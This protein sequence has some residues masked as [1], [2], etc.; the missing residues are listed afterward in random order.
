MSRQYW[1]YGLIG[2][3]A[4]VVGVLLDRVL[5]GHGGP[6]EPRK[7]IPLQHPAEPIP[8][9]NTTAPESTKLPSP[10][11]S[12]AEIPANPKPAAKDLA[13]ILAEPDR[14]QRMTDL[15]AF[16]NS[17]APGAYGNALRGLRRISS[18][19]ERDL[20][21]RLL[22]ARWVQTDPE[23]AL[24]F[25]MA[26]RNYE[27]IANEVFQSEAAND[28]TTALGRA[29]A[30]T[31]PEL[32]YQ[33]LLGV[34]SFMADSN[35]SQAL[36]MAS[37]LGDI[38]GNEPLSNVIYRQWATNDPQ[39]AALAAAQA[40]GDGGWRSPI[41]QVARTW[42]SDDPQAA[43]NWSVGLTDREAQM[44]SISQVMRQWTRDDVSGATNWANSLPPGTSYDA[45]AAG[46][47]TSLA[48]NH[49]QDA[50]SWAQNISDP[51]MRTNVLQRVSREVMWRNP[52]NGAEI[53]GA[54][55]VPANLIPQPGNGGGRRRRGGGG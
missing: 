27:F 45:A 29:K 18:T 41:S 10:A 25:A 36:Q 14:R 50:V 52:T 8:M 13:T 39:G 17:L 47:A 11:L 3:I 26:N 12:E 22:V 20:A 44:R 31:S 24:N 46:L 35:P 34:L 21:S 4:L 51:T 23:A 48:A 15:E 19:N 28:V 42:A 9:A 16:I 5:V 55:G 53:L 43:A 54:A 2:G 6:A 33:A 40:G 1:R 7:E 30:L 37:G 32:R 49:P 38:P